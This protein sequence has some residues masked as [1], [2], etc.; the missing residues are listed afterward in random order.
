MKRALVP[1]LVL[2][3]L[4]FSGCFIIP[5]AV[6][7]ERPLSTQYDDAGIKTSIAADLLEENATQ[8]N[9][10]NVHCFEGQVFLIGEAE[11]SFRAFAV[12]TASKTDGVI[13]V[14]PHWFPP[15][16]GDTIH[17]A[18]LEAD[19]DAALLFTKDLP[20]AQVVVDV[21]GG[22]VVLTGIMKNQADIEKTISVAKGVKGVKSV[23]SY[24]FPS[25]TGRTAE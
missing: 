20:S 4:S 6:E 8:A 16:T 3:S 11:K 23:T 10:V 24:L 19:V 17:D 13:H 12:K 1:L 5:S 25:G 22:H 14:T 7:D 21:W 18:G 9:G 2:C 15:G